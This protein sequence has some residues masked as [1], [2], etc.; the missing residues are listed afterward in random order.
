MVKA[1]VADETG[2]A[3][4]FFK[5]DNAKLIKKDAVI[6][7]RNGKVRF[8]KGHISLE[9]DIFGRITQEKV[10]IAASTTKNIS[11]K[12]IVRRPRQNRRRDD[13]DGEK[14]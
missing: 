4:A 13:D 1:V 7:I 5:G 12:E 10:D 9:V 2:C 11:E 6:A 14:R 8:I 3:D